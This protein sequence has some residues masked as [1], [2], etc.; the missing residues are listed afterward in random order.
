MVIDIPDAN[1]IHSKEQYTSDG[2][3]VFVCSL[4]LFA[5][6]MPNPDND[7]R[8]TVIGGEMVCVDHQSYVTPNGNGR[9]QVLHLASMM[10]EEGQGR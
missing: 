2:G 6:K 5:P 7:D 4:C 1:P 9:Y 3:T 8:L 10:R